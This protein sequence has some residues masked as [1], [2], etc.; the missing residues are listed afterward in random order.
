MRDLWNIYESRKTFDISISL[1]ELDFKV[2][3]FNFGT[4]KGVWFFSFCFVGGGGM[5][6]SKANKW[7]NKPDS[8]MN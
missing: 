8:K 6:G 1:F 2:E 4:R 7:F 3:Y 5:E